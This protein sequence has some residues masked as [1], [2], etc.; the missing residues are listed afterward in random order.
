MAKQD[1]QRKTK[2]VKLLKPHTDR[3]IDYRAGDTI[4]VDAATEQWLIAH[5]IIESTGVTQ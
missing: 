2:Q 1:A 4:E 5:Q 3:G